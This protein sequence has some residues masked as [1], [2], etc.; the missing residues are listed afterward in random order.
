MVG[1][2]LISHLVTGDQENVC[3]F[4]GEIGTEHLGLLRI[5]LLEMDHRR[6]K[7]CSTLYVLLTYSIAS[8]EDSGLLGLIPTEKHFILPATLENF[9]CASHPKR[10]VLC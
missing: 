3:L 6:S 5:V 8:S 4:A 10:A 7:C 1:K 9:S 2:L